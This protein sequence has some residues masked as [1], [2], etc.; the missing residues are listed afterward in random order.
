VTLIAANLIPAPATLAQVM[1]PDSWND[2]TST[3]GTPAG[4]LAA[5]YALVEIAALDTA[6]PL[7]S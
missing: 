1:P 4:A 5:V 7:A 2:A 6:G 3:P